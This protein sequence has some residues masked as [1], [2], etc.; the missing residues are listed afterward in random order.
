MSARNETHVPAEREQNP[1]FNMIK[2]PIFAQ[3]E[4]INIEVDQD[5]A[6]PL[7]FSGLVAAL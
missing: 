2:K 6:Y 1:L 7:A 4:K 3:E 5:V